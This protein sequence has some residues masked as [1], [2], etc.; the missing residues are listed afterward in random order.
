MAEQADAADLNS[1]AR[2]G[3]RVRISAPAPSA[4]GSCASSVRPCWRLPPGMRESRGA[5]SALAV[6]R[7][8]FQGDGKRK[9]GRDMR[10]VASRSPTESEPRAD[11]AE[12]AGKASGHE[13][14]SRN[15]D[16]GNEGENECI[17]RETLSFLAVRAREHIASFRKRRLA[18][19]ATSS[20]RF[21]ECSKGPTIRESSKDRHITA[22]RSRN[23]RT[24]ANVTA[25]LGDRARGIQT[26]A[27]PPTPGPT[28]PRLMGGAEAAAARDALWML[29]LIVGP[30]LAGSGA[31]DRDDA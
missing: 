11:R 14:E 20:G 4:P 17:F 29:V 12:K 6:V 28:F 18:L 5:L 15:G 3:V 13:H 30:S 7:G 22:R 31:G 19:V 10:P 16:H 24:A 1:A 26:G 9:T 25:A 8:S 2:E 23:F 27:R 21:F